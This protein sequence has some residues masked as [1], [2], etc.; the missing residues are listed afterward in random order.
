MS[1]S[2]QIR[3]LNIK[4]DMPNVE[5]AR[6]RLLDEIRS[7]RA[8][9]VSILKVIHGYGSSGKGG[10]LRQALRK[11]LS[12]RRKEGLV[13]LVIYGEAWSVFDDSARDLLD[14][15]PALGRDQDLNN[16]NE[17]ITLVVL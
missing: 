14:R 1:G 13:R 16:S 5:D 11:S 2:Q 4:D 17:G 8:G 6:R 3:V 15:Y 7:A 12:R 10:A 9:G